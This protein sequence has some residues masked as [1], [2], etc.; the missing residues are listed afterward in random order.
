MATPWPPAAHAVMRAS[1]LSS[2][3]RRSVAHLRR[4]VPVAPKGCPSE[5]DP[6]R[7]FMISTLISPT[8]SMPRFSLHHASESSAAMLESTCP[9]KASWNSM[10]SMSDILRLLRLRSCAV[11]C[12]G[13][14]SSCVLGS[15]P[16]KTKSLRSERYLMPRDLAYSSEVMIEAE[17]PSVR[18]DDEAAVTVPWGFTKAGLRPPSFSTVVGRMPL[19]TET[20][21][22]LVPATGMISPLKSPWSVA[23]WAR[24]CERAANLSWSAREMLNEAASLSAE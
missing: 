7:V 2:N 8:L 13:P 6:P 10:M 20:I 14:S 11:E 9:A 19:S 21:F 23:S 12:A 16:A 22:P 5:S 4:R 24:W 17:A 1:F 3:F 15:H 18:K